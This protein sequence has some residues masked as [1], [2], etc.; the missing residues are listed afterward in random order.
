[1][2]PQAGGGAEKKKPRKRPVARKLQRVLRKLGAAKAVVTTFVVADEPWLR[3]K[4]PE[5]HVG[6]LAKAA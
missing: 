2:R 5:A 4:I 6:L 3:I 1:M